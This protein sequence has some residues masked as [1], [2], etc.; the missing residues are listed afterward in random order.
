[1]VALTPQ[2]QRKI[3]VIVGA[4]FEVEAA[5][6]NAIVFKNRK[7]KLHNF[8][9]YCGPLT[10]SQV[11]QVA[12]ILEKV[13]GGFS[14]DMRISENPRP[15]N[16]NTESSSKL[17]RAVLEL[18]S[19]NLH[20]LLLLTSG[21]S[22]VSY[23]CID[24][25]ITLVQNKDEFC[26]DPEILIGFDNFSKSLNN[27][28]NLYALPGWSTETRLASVYA[29]EVMSADKEYLE[30]ASR[31]MSFFTKNS[32]SVTLGD[33]LRVDFAEATVTKDPLGNVLQ[34]LSYIKDIRKL[35]LSEYR[36]LAES[37]TASEVISLSDLL[38]GGLI[39][40]HFSKDILRNRSRTKSK[41]DLFYDN[42]SE[43]RSPEPGIVFMYLSPDE[44]SFFNESAL[45]D[46]FD[47][48]LDS[49]LSFDP[50]HQIVHAAIA[51]V[52]VVKGEHKAL[53]VARTL[54]HLRLA[55]DLG[56]RHYEATVALI[57]ESLKPENDELPFGWATQLSEHAWVLSSHLQENELFEVSL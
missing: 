40:G 12:A 4:T 52:L 32:E 28:Y 19:S 35:M 48:L 54:E 37:M 3:E 34:I 51:E 7:L 10:E 27:L 50:T 55:S 22:M 17:V 33:H 1:M 8:Y 23:D 11:L 49:A 43:V 2:L 36:E 46:E 57:A 21:N 16:S 24:L 44:A 41:C 38:S 39:D 45:E 13:F 18:D 29:G 26:S 25:A 6:S 53:E 30:L 9:L 47:F 31:L 20:K 42:P 56:L 5:I 14:I 15:L